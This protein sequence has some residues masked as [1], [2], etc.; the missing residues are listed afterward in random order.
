MAKAWE[1]EGK[2]VTKLT[3]VDLMR[4]PVHNKVFQILINT[5]LLPSEPTNSKLLLKL[6]RM[7]FVYWCIKPTD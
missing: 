6:C 2:T 3:G 7:G 1:G 4:N 5:L